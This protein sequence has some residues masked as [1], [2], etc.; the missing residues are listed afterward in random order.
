[1]KFGQRG[2]ENEF[3]RV[4]EDFPKKKLLHALGNSMNDFFGIKVLE[5][6]ARLE[7]RSSN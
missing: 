4:F 6:M 7:P 2:L 5:E 1:M 3:Q